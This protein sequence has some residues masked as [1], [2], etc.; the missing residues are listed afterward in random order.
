MNKSEEEE[1]EMGQCCFC[2]FECNPL[3]QSC[4]ACSR[5]LSGVA[6]GIPI[7]D[8]LQEYI[9]P[10]SYCR[11]CGETSNLIHMK[12][13][14]NYDNSSFSYCKNCYSD[15]VLSCEICN[16]NIQAF[17]CNKNNGYIYVCYL[18][19]CDKIECNFC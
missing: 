1:E 2:G 7:P 12:D 6:V 16:K 18:C 9:M 15:P 4:G 8:H 10:V 11:N 3:S 14:V 5:G 17:K 19:K 13:I